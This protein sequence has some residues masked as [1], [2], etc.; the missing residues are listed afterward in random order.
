MIY[1]KD[2]KNNVF[3]YEKSLSEKEVTKRKLELISDADALKILEA[4]KKAR[5]EALNYAE[6][7]SSK[8]PSIHD[9]VGAIMKWIA[10]LDQDTLPDELKEMCQEVEDVKQ[11]FPNK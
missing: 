10:T 8:F 11:E 4:K 5:F 3:G 7:R 6:K 2:A 9:Q 1:Y